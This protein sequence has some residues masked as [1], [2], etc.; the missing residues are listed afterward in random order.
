MEAPP[1]HAA[2]VRASA[3]LQIAILPPLRAYA[4]AARSGMRFP[5]PTSP[6]GR[7]P[8]R[9]M[10]PRSTLREGSVK[11]RP[12]CGVL[13]FLLAANDAVQPAAGHLALA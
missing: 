12:E 7:L 3:E 1:N 10:Q 6:S 11:T 13:S 4:W 8:R 5:Q 9:E 2:P